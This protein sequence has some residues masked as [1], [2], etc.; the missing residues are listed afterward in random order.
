M[1]LSIGDYGKFLFELML[2]PKKDL[3]KHWQ[4]IADEARPLV[5]KLLE[6]NQ[7]MSTGGYELYGY[8]K[9]GKMVDP[10]WIRIFNAQAKTWQVPANSLKEGDLIWIPNEYSQ[11]EFDSPLEVAEITKKSILLVRPGQSLE[12]NDLRATDGPVRISLNDTVFKVPE[13]FEE[14]QEQY[15]SG[16]YWLALANAYGI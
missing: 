12:D 2:G 1:Q 8:L 4:S 9:D 5:Q 7:K 16:D 10:N 3:S 14:N 13:D 15:E 6:L 11:F